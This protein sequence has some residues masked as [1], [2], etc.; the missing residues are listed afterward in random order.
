MQVSQ[1]KQTFNDSYARKRLKQSS[2]G[3]YSIV[4]FTEH[5][6]ILFSYY[7]GIDHSPSKQRYC[8]LFN[9]SFLTIRSTILVN[10]M[11]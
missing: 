5:F 10:Q 6:P 9:P 7:N 11:S 4:V 1:K 2:T 3:Y 8:L